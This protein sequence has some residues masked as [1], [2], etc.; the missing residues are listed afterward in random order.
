MKVSSKKI[1]IIVQYN[2]VQ[3][4]QYSIILIQVFKPMT[5]R[6]KKLW[7]RYDFLS[8]VFSLSRTGTREY[9]H[10]TYLP[11]FEADN[12]FF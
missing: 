4:N 5:E 11:M 1:K 8:I 10:D 7:G 3:P 9:R 6:F 12:T 2:L